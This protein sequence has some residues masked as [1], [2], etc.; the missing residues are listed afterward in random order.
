MPRLRLLHY[1]PLSSFSIHP[2][3]SKRFPVPDRPSHRAPRPIPRGV[4][5][6]TADTI[7]AIIAHRASRLEFV[8]TATPATTRSSLRQRRSG[9]TQ[10]RH[11]AAQPGPA[12]RARETEVDR[13]VQVCLHPIPP[14]AHPTTQCIPAQRLPPKRGRRVTAVHVPSTSV[15]D[16]TFPDLGGPLLAAGG[17]G[18]RG[19]TSLLPW[20]P[21]TS[22]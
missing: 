9:R 21:L 10:G 20:V 5:T 7:D 12:G 6:N 22:V 14:A 1:L 16:K 19:T 17:L 15:L 4:E 3:P 11:T 18:L 13:D 2:G 8:L